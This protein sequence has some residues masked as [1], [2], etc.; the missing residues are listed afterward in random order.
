MDIKEYIKQWKICTLIFLI[1]Y[2]RCLIFKRLLT[3]RNECEFTVYDIRHP[4]GKK[5]NQ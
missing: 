4:C 5:I 3:V 1:M 2:I